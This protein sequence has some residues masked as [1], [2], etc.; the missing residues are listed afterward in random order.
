MRN[1]GINTV[2]RRIDPCLHYACSDTLYELAL[3]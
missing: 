1:P 3:G 2:E